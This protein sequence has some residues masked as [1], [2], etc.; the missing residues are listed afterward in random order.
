[1]SI[2]HFPLLLLLFSANFL[3][4]FDGKYTIEMPRYKISLTAQLSVY[5]LYDSEVLLPR[6]S[7]EIQAGGP[8]TITMA[9]LPP[10]VHI[11]IQL[12]KGE[13]IVG[14]RTVLFLNE[15]ET[16]QKWGGMN[17]VQDKLGITITNRATAPETSEEQ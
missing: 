10:E 14:S 7:H 8:R 1:M 17:C 13:K 4:S 2:K 12:L 5:N 3:I 9:N 6:R 15:S 16:V 11:F